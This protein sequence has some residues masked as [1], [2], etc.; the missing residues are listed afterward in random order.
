MT[1]GDLPTASLQAC[2]LLQE[3]AVPLQNTTVTTFSKLLDVLTQ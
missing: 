2:T 3:S 1:Q